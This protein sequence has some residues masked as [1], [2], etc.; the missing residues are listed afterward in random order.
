ME[1]IEIAQKRKLAG[2]STE[3][4]ADDLGVSVERVREWETGARK[5][6]SKEAR[7]FNWFVAAAERQAAVAQSGLPECEW[8]SRWDNQELLTDPEKELES[9]RALEK[10]QDE[11]PTCRARTAYLEE[12]FPPL[13]PLPLPWWQR[14][15]GPILDLDDRLRGF[16]R[17]VVVSATVPLLF[18]LGWLLG[19]APRSWPFQ[20]LTYFAALGVAVVCGLG[21]YR[22]LRPLHGLGAMGRWLA[23]SIAGVVAMVGFGAVVTLA[24]FGGVLSSDGVAPS[25]SQIVWLGVVMGLAFALIWPFAS[26]AYD[27]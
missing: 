24:G 13:P 7:F 2:L 6:A 26:A 5:M 11:C 8:M 17:V 9:V 18:S 22:G 14:A 21:L 16:H 1:P 25:W 12:R 4:L 19:F 3:Q 10:H 20:V 23:R 15:L 27:K